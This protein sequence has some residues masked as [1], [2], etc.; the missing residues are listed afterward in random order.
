MNTTFISRNRD[1]AASV[2]KMELSI[3]QRLEQFKESRRLE[4]K[5]NYLEKLNRTIRTQKKTDRILRI[6][7]R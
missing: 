3:N 1:K 4:G 7:K 5:K 2:R 6:L